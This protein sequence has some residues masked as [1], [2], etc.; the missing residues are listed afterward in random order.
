MIKTFLDLK[1]AIIYTSGLITNKEFKNN[2]L[3]ETEWNILEELKAIFEIFVKPT[4]K[5]QGEIYTTLNKSFL[6][7]Y[8]IFT[9]LEN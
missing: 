8:Q 9:K 1:L 2:T 3:I 5:L 7:I 6:L 4:I